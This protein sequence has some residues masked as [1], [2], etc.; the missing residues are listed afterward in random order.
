MPDYTFIIK[1]I[2]S[3]HQRFQIELNSYEFN[4]QSI[5]I[6]AKLLPKNP[7]HKIS[8]S[9]EFIITSSGW[10]S[11]EMAQNN[12][13]KFIHALMI[14]LTLERI[15]FDFGLR[16]S[17]LDIKTKQYDW[18]SRYLA[19]EA[20]VEDIHGVKVIETKDIKKI[21]RLGKTNPIIRSEIDTI[22]QYLKQAIEHNHR[23]TNNQIISVEAYNSSF[24]QDNPDIKFLLRFI[25][26]EALITQDRRSQRIV[27]H[28]EELIGHT[29]KSNLE[30]NE[31]DLLTSAI[32][33]LKNQSIK[34]SGAELVSKHLGSKKYMD[35][36]ASKFFEKCY[37]VRSE[38]VHK[39][40]ALQ[41]ITEISK[42][43]AELEFFVP[44][45][46]YQ[47]I[48]RTEKKI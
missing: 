20:P 48:M 38:L 9:T 21:P 27:E 34:Q 15:G 46:I 19:L 39:R 18:I 36:P 3:P 4:L 22:E 2:I 10:K 6:P 33:S 44:E 37:K 1:F 45:L 8:E 31:K 14:A 24:F 25:A 11:E 43:S 23:L 28:I 30:P 29:K 26:V 5:D 32:G 40:K 12:G 35:I 42:L 17:Q 7:K 41:S 13:D 47:T 16:I